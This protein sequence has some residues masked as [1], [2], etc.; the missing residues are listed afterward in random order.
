MT[1]IIAS[2]N[3]LKTQTPWSLHLCSSFYSSNSYLFGFLRNPL[4]RDDLIPFPL[5]LKPWWPA[6]YLNIWN[7]HKVSISA[8]MVTS[9]VFD[10]AAHVQGLSFVSKY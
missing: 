10:N 3:D 1:G 6:T 8:I 9:L 5:V 2:L 4:K 7:G